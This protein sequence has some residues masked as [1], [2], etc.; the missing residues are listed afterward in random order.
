[1]FYTI[2]S[3]KGIIEGLIIR[4]DNTFNLLQQGVPYL[5][6]YHDLKV[7]SHLITNVNN[8]KEN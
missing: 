6:Q 3:V 5:I 2:S 4:F 1:M 7:L 8:H